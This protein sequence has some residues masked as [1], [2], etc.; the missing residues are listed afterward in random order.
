MIDFV[1]AGDC[2]IFIKLGNSIDPETN[3]RVLAA[4]RLITAASPKGI[5]ELV[6]SYA[7]V[8]VY[9]N[10]LDTGY[11]QLTKSI[12]LILDNS[13]TEKE[14]NERTLISIPVCYSGDLAPDIKFVASHNG[15]STDEVINIHTEATYLVY[16]IGF[17][18]GFPYLGGMD[19]RIATPRR[20]EPRTK[21]KG[22]SV[23]IAGDQTGIYPLDSP[24]GWQIIGHTPLRL[25][26]P[27]A[28]DPFL[29]RSGNLL[30]FKPVDDIEYKEIE[31]AITSKSYKPEITVADERY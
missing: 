16:M 4:T 3:S 15:I 14:G 30:K 7:G 8:M 28:T 24:G 13:D 11:E 22:G 10:P 5:R 31:R 17:T 1:R 9:Y 26:D 23:G 25:F 12:T 19:R 2:A 27:E 29:L 21:V 18:P 6:P 20:F